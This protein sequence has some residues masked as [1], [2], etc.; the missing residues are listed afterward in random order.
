MSKH[1]MSSIRPRKPIGRVTV[2]LY[3]YANTKHTKSLCSKCPP[4]ARIR[5]RKRGRH[6]A[7]DRFI[8]ECLLKMFLLFDQTLRLI[9]VM[10]PAAVHTLLQLLPNKIINRVSG[11]LAGHRAVE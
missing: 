10:N 6:C 5:A 9:D 7:P 11:P 1:E 2:K 8:S 4:C 3:V